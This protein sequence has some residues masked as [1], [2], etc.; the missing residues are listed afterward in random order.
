MH[1]A[2]RAVIVA[3]LIAVTTPAAMSATSQTSITRMD[4]ALDAI[5]FE[6]LNREC[7]C[8]RKPEGE[9]D[10]KSKPVCGFSMRERDPGPARHREVD[11]LRLERT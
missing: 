7:G 10:T 2:F 3:S 1:I 8:D 5:A 9:M 6:E 11:S 4:P